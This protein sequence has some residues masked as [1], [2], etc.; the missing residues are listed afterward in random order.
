MG[1]LASLEGTLG[2]GRG[3]SPA[4]TIKGEASEGASAGLEPK[5]LSYDAPA[6]VGTAPPLADGPAAKRNDDPDDNLKVTDEQALLVQ[7]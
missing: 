2:R 4:T 1:F 7:A 3:T 5:S 6:G